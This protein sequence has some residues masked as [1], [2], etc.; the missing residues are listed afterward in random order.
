MTEWARLLP[1]QDAAEV[2]MLQYINYTDVGS[3]SPSE[4]L[5]STNDKCQKGFL[6]TLKTGR[7]NFPSLFGEIARTSDNKELFRD[8]SRLRVPWDPTL[9]NNEQGLPETGDV[10]KIPRD[11]KSV[12]K[13]DS[14]IRCSVRSV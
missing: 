8:R 13:I 2:N 14:S 1:S 10:P 9:G 6:M 7:R 12:R 11:N 3:R 4:D 5:A